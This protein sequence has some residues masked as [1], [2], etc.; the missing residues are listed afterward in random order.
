MRV[1]IHN[2]IAKTSVVVSS[3]NWSSCELVTACGRTDTTFTDKVRRFPKGSRA[4]CAVSLKPALDLAHKSGHVPGM[5]IDCH[6][7]GC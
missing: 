7:N 6:P 2:I 4:S 1:H 3:D 5:C